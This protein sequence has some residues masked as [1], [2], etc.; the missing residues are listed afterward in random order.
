MARSACAAATEASCSHW[1]ASCHGLSRPRLPRSRQRLQTQAAARLFH[2]RHLHENKKPAFVSDQ[3]ITAALVRL[4]NGLPSKYRERCQLL[5]CS[6]G[7]LHPL[8]VSARTCW[9]TQSTI[10]PSCAT[11]NFACSS[12]QGA[13]TSIWG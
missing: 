8:V 4:S 3:S 5:G 1:Q 7:S 13:M 11:A 10:L 9:Y 6:P 12:I 2:S